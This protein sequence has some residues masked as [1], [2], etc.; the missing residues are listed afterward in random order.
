MGAINALTL[1]H[2]KAFDSSVTF[3]FKEKNALVFGENGSGKTSVF[4]AMKMAFFNEK[5]KREEIRS[6]D[7]PEEET[8]KLRQLYEGYRNA[9]STTPFSILINGV[10]YE[11]LTRE[12]Y[13]VFLVT[14]DDFELDQD[15]ILLSDK[16]S[17]MYFDYGSLSSDDFI[18]TFC[19]DLVTAVNKTLREQ[20]SETVT[21]KV[22]KGDR[23]RCVLSD[24]EG[25][26][27]YGTHLSR[28]YN[29]GKIHL[30]LIII[31]INVFLLLSDKTKYNILVL[32]DFITSLDAA[33]RAFVIRFLFDAVKKQESIQ[34]F[35]FTHNVSFYNLTKYYINNYLASV[36]S[37]NWNY[38]NLYN[39]GEAHKL[40]PQVDDSIAK[41]QKDLR[42][43]VAPIENIG[44]RIRQLFEI[45]VHELAKI[46]ISGGLEESKDVLARLNEGRPIYYK[47]GKNVYDLVQS[48]ENIAKAPLF[49][50]EKLSKKIL[51][52]I[53]AYKN[54]LE[55]QN[56]R[57]TLKHMTLFQKISLHPTSHGTLGLA[58]VSQKEIK[59]S[60]QLLKKIRQ[61][62]SKLKGKDVINM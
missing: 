56:L 7:T 36:E 61:C 9:K 10:S 27:Y 51:S 6:S 52:T 24:A 29:E 40:Y 45:Q 11:T 33:N 37:D 32:D 48:L 28:Y 57:E 54:D 49:H 38:F 8:E 59:E 53:D 23:F 5:L 43:G 46:I 26:L 41:V 1:S 60:I 47:G 21:M 35:I 19:D 17:K 30:I 15:C 20:F 18:K 4:E 16:L 31:Y 12:D 62:V 58:P 3:P 14:H 42:E 55:L 13:K 44:N 25:K 22:E 34:L 50:R 39:L 2:F